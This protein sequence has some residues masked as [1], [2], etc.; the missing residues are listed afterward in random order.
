MKSIDDCEFLNEENNTEDHVIFDRKYKISEY[1]T[2]KGAV[3]RDFQNYWKV[4]KESWVFFDEL[5]IF[6]C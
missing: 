6:D 4:F 2:F 3:S 5:L 1:C